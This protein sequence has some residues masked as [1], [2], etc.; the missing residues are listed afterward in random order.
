MAGGATFFVASL[1]ELGDPRRLAGQAW[2]LATVEL[3]YEQFNRQ[4]GDL[5]PSTPRETFAAQVRMVQEWRRFPLLDPGLPAEVLPHPWM[6]SKA[7]ALFRARHATWKPAA[8]AMW[9]ALMP[10]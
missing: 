9:R 1:G 6:G 4:V 10:S 5:R 7:T 8:A 2:N 3:R